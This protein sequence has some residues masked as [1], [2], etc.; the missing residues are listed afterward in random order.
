[1]IMDKKGRIRTR[2]TL[3][4]T[5]GLSLQRWTLWK[6]RFGVI[7]HREGLDEQ[8]QEL[9]GQGVQIMLSVEQSSQT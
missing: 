9:V 8:L 3:R 6:N 5:D 4:G 1:M 2:G 7:R